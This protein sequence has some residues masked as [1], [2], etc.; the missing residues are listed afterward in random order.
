MQPQSGQTEP[1]DDA[2]RPSWVFDNLELRPGDVVLERSTGKDSAL[3]MAF[4]GGAYCHALLWAGG[5][6]FIEAVDKG[7]RSISYMRVPVDTPENWALLRYVGAGERSA[8]VAASAALHAR[9]LVFKPYNLKGAIASVTPATIQSKTDLFCSELVAEAYR[10]AGDTA[11]SAT[12]PHRTTPRV[13]EQSAA[14][15]HITPLPL[16]EG[17]S[18]IAERGASYAQT[19]MSREM[20]LA[21]ATFATVMGRH[22]HTLDAEAGRL[23]L[24]MGNLSDILNTLAVCDPDLGEPIAA[25]TNDLLTEGGYYG[26]LD[27]DTKS[28]VISRAP[29]S[30][31][32]TVLG[33]RTTLWRHD[34]NLAVYR[35]IA[36]DR[37]WP[38]WIAHVALA[39]ELSAFFRHLVTLAPKAASPP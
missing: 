26:F 4:D 27:P 21:Q 12:K 11:L 10:R 3:I 33:W 6:D 2:A 34:Q 22:G 25:L 29:G 7:A 9:N 5:S 36:V 37:P 1:A 39:E 17:L 13:L 30:S 15:E 14:F 23:G 18:P 31:P 24:P 16:K 28:G 8:A 35:S 38:L 20:L 19:T 32:D